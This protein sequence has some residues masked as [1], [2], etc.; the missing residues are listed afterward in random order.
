MTSDLD[1]LASIGIDDGGYASLRLAD[2]TNEKRRCPWDKL[3]FV[4]Q[5]DQ[6]QQ[7]TVDRLGENR[8]NYCLAKVN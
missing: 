8:L 1:G 2:I 6:L 3:E 5:M 4:G 7:V